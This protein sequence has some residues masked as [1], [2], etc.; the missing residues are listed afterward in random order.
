M[1]FLYGSIS[2]ISNVTFAAYRTE[3]GQ[4][5]VLPV[6]RTVE[7]QLACD[8]TL[9]KEY[10]PITGMPDLTKNAVNMLLGNGHKMIT[11]NRVSFMTHSSFD[12]N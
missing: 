9:N 10:L 6:V 3:E 1:V 8:E 5:W 7:S 12:S 4:P 2:F 11:E